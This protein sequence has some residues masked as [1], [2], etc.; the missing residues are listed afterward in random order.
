MALALGVPRMT[1]PGL[2]STPVIPVEMYW[3]GVNVFNST[4]RFI[5]YL[6]NFE[7]VI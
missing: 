7:Q 5:L 2:L 6:C 4:L 3:I 1:E